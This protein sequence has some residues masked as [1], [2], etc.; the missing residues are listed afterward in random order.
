[1]MKK[2]HLKINPL[3]LLFRP[4]V[5]MIGLVILV[6]VLL[7]NCAIAPSPWI[8]TPGTFTLH[9]LDRE[10]LMAEYRALGGRKDDVAGFALYDREPCVIYIRVDQVNGVVLN[11]ELR[12]CREK[13]S[14]HD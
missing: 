12:H 14:W 4:L 9:V 13:G 6:V 3:R 8:I 2:T 1:M 11:H 10:E 7:S 5:K